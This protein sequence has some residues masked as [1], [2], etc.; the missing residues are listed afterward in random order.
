MIGTPP[1]RSDRRLPIFMDRPLKGQFK[2]AERLEARF[3]VIL[4][5]GRDRSAAP[6][7]SRTPRPA[8]RRRSRSSAPSTAI[9]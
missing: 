9:S 7:T 2:Q 4:W 5:R 6:S 3:T 1:R 8:S